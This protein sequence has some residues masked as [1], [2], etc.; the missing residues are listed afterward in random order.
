MKSGW[1]AFGA[2]I[3]AAPS[4]A[5]TADPLAPIV[6]KPPNPR[7]P[8][9]TAT[10][11]QPS[12][13]A[14]RH[15]HARPR[16][17]RNRPGAQGLARRVRRDRCRQLGVRAGGD[18]RPSARDPDAGREGRTL[19]RQGFAAGR[20]CLDPG[21]ARRGARAS[22]GRPAR[23]GSRSRAA[24]RQAP[25]IVA[26]RPVVNLGSPPGRYRARPVQGEPAAD[27]LRAAA[28]SAGQ[29]RRRP[30]R[31]SAAADLRA[32]DFPTKPAP[33]RR[34]GSPSFITCS[35]STWTPGASP[36]PGASARSATGRRRPPGSPASPRGG[37]ATANSA[38]R[39]F[40]EVARTA[41]QRE[42]RA[43]GL[44]WTAR[45]EQACRRPQSVEPLSCARRAASA[46][47][48]YGLIARETLGMDTRLPADPYVQRDPAVDNLPNVRR[49]IELASIGEAGAGRGNASPPG[50]DLRA[51]RAPRPDPGRQAARPARRAAVAG[52]HRPAGRA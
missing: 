23:A 41:Q 28:R 45:A 30:G 44:Y 38:S 39:A 34:P 12:T 32:A 37:W 11:A 15:R 22:P 4:L 10:T 31:R 24:R 19:H 26:E 16:P 2:M 18:R 47:S 49:A 7:T 52:Q 46:E 33:R 25:L 3:W 1:F 36:I 35:G 13:A 9:P 42:L 43:G 29:G 17:C 51:V 20:S 14:H 40:Q 48:F 5:Q 6:A 50:A 27:Q 8:G 21:A